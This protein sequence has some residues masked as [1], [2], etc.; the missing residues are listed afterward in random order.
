MSD[1]ALSG[2]HGSSLNVEFRSNR[3]NTDAG[4]FLAIV[5]IYTGP[6]TDTPPPTGLP[7]PTGAPPPGLGLQQLTDCMPSQT[8]RPRPGRV[9]RSDKQTT[10]EKHFVRY[11][12]VHVDF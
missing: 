6:L 4:F 8:L 11:M 12:H 10:A 7:G 1:V 3:I 9:V 5:C 2:V